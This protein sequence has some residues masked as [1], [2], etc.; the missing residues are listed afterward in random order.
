MKFIV[1]ASV[2][3]SAALAEVAFKEQFDSGKS[4]EQV[5]TFYLSPYATVPRLF[6]KP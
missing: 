4:F 3:V 6:R 2:L 5:I 1:L